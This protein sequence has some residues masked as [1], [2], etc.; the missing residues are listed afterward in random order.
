MIYNLSPTEIKGVVNIPMIQ[1]VLIEN[2]SQK[3]SQ[4]QNENINLIIFTSAKAVNYL[5]NFWMDWQ[6]IDSVAIGKKT[7]ETIKKLGGKLIFEAVD[8]HGDNFANEILK[9]FK[10]IKMLYVRPEKVESNIGEILKKANIDLIELI[11]YKTV[12][13]LSHTKI[14]F[15]INQKHIFIISSPSIF[16]CFLKYLQINQIEISNNFIFITI[17]KTTFKA[18]PEKYNKYISQEQTLESCFELANKIN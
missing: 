18:I 7:G 4:I 13:N 14:N 3:I 2:L 11:L 5:N 17:G 6:K 10:N 8:S 1:T 12:C 9:N 15:L 16:N